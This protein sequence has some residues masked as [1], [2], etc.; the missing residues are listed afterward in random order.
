MVFGKIDDPRVLRR[1]HNPP[2]Q[3]DSLLPGA[4]VRSRATRY[5]IRSTEHHTDCHAFSLVGVGQPTENIVLL[6][7]FDRIVP[8][9]ERAH[10][11]RVSPTGV[12]GT[13]GRVWLD[14]FG[15]Q[16]LG[17]VAARAPSLQVVGWQLEAARLLREGRAS[18]VLIADE[19]GL[20]KTVQAGLVHIALSDDPS[21]DRTLIVVPSGLRDQWSVELERLF[22]LHPTIVDATHLRQ[23][24][25]RLPLSVNPWAMPGVFIAAIDF[26]K[27]PEVLA[28]VLA[29]QWT[30]VVLDEAHGLVGHSD[31]HRAARL[32][33]RAA[34]YVVMLTATPHPGDTGAF[35]RL[36]D[37]GRTGRDQVI[38]IRR[39]R[40]DVSFKGRRRV[41]RLTVHPTHAER[42]LHA[43]LKTY[44]KRLRRER[45]MTTEGTHLIGWVLMKRAASSTH[46]LRLTLQRRR[47]ALLCAAPT[48]LQTALPFCFDPGELQDEDAWLP[49]IIDAPG[50]QDRQSEL[51]LLESLLVQ[52]ANVSLD[53]RKLAAAARLVRRAQQPVIVFTEFRD[54]LERIVEHLP[55]VGTV[56]LH[57]G[58][59]RHNRQAAERAFVAGDANVLV[60]TD[61]ASEGLNL[62]ARCRLVIHFDVPWNPTRLEQRIG[63]VDRIGQ[64]RRVHTVTLMSGASDPVL[65]QRLERKLER[66]DR[67]LSC[68]AGVPVEPTGHHAVGARSTSAV[69]GSRVVNEQSDFAASAVGLVRAFASRGARAGGRARGPWLPWASVSHALRVRLGLPTGVLILF[70]VEAWTGRATRAAVSCIPVLVELEPAAAARFA[71]KRLIESCAPA[72]ARVAA[73]HAR[74]ALASA[75]AAHVQRISALEHRAIA[76]LQE[77]PMSPSPYQPGLFD[78]RAMTVALDRRSL[79]ASRRANLTA[80]LA[81][82][83]QDRRIECGDHVR[84]VAAFVLR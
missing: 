75:I 18:R 74:A 51:A 13:V 67:E 54:T 71:G 43:D 19:V 17:A 27:Q 4:F 79:D 3:P 65:L 35:G 6:T 16:R 5:R 25:R 46:A 1:T 61:A 37:I 78:K 70:G 52:A 22:A 77:Q 24:R 36:Q 12:A 58:M 76:A 81:S 28:S 82:L 50:L 2:V 68:A 49:A 66:I 7:P 69:A 41:V 45:V 42:R 64:Q 15:Q 31:R 62:Q 60:A 72:A 48:P 32:T 83:E 84:A 73:H 53:E 44:L 56:T 26:I 11:R 40:A 38:V 23:M 21:R 63:R 10:W 39:T 9:T 20:G 29:V 34:Q 47:D 55:L 30:L 57:G 8:V 59:E 14:T 33:A 80:T